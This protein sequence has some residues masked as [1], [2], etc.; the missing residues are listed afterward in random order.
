MH[1]TLIICTWQQNRI[2][3]RILSGPNGS[4]LKMSMTKMPSLRKVSVMHILPIKL[5]RSTEQNMTHVQRGNITRHLVFINL[6]NRKVYNTSKPN[7][8]LWT[9]FTQARLYGCA[10]FSVLRPN[11][12]ISRDTKF[13]ILPLLIMNSHCFPLAMQVVWKILC[14][15]HVFDFCA[16]GVVK[17][18]WINK[19]STLSSP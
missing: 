12:T 8:Y 18:R 17:T 6:T 11:L 2:T 13:S 5:L 4:F 7:R 10:N 3:F 14:R 19:A 16:L 9:Y 1:W 15:R